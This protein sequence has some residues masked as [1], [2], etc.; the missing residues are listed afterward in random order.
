MKK[1]IVILL[2][3]F[4][5]LSANCQEKPKKVTLLW[6]TSFSMAD[7]ELSNE[8]GFL[9]SYFKTNTNLTINLIK[10]SNDIILNQSFEVSNG[11]WVLLKKEL[12][13]TVY[14]GASSFE[15]L[16]EITV[17]DEILFFTDGNGFIDDF[18]KVFLKPV[19]IISSLQDS[20]KINLKKV[21]ELSKGLYFDLSEKEFKKTKQNLVISMSGI[22]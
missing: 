16:K 12:I 19:K 7:K 8:M 5:S 2:V 18:P 22:V 21:A 20:N 4:I 11:N 1:Y 9:N 15:T 6:D 3:L 13:N 17:G 10:F 14:D